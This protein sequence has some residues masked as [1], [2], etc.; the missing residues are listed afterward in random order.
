MFEE[1]DPD[2]TAYQ[3]NDYL[4]SDY[5]INGYYSKQDEWQVV[6]PKSEAKEIFNED[7]GELIGFLKVGSP[8]VD[9][10][11]FG[12]RRDESGIWSHEPYEGNF[13]RIANDFN[14]FIQL[15]QSRLLK[16]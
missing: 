12:Y 8:G 15:F 14:E 9:G 13:R 1:I 6:L 7:E 11:S 16:W 10:I 2:F 5:A 4:N 3:C